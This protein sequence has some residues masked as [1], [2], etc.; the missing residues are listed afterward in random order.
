MTTANYVQKFD[1]VPQFWQFLKGLRTDDLLVELIQNDLDASAKHTMISFEPDRLVCQGDGDPVEAE[2]WERLSYVMGA[3]DQVQSKQF[4]IGVK[5]HGLK[6]CFN[7]GDD[8]T[9]RS[10]GL[11]TVQTLYMDGPDSHP[12]PGTLPCPEADYSAPAE[13]CSVEVPYRTKKLAVSKGEPFELEPTDENYTDRLFLEACSTLPA[14]LMGVVFPGVRDH[15][16]LSLNHHKLG[17]VEIRWK[18]KRPKRIA[19]KGRIRFT[20]FSRECEV[21]SDVSSVKSVT[22]YEQACAFRR[23]TPKGINPEV[24]EFFQPEKKSFRMETAWATDRHGRPA[25]TRGVRRYPIGY[26]G[27]ADSALSCLGAHFA[28]PYRSDGERH[29]ASSQDPLNAHID[30]ACREALVDIMACYLLPRHG[31]RVMAL[32]VAEPQPNDES[33]LDMLRRSIEKKAIPIEP[34]SS[35]SRRRQKPAV[36]NKRQGFRSRSCLGPRR[37]PSGGT[38]RILIPAFTWDEE[39]VAP[40]LSDLCPAGE[41]QIDK[42][43]PPSVFKHLAKYHFAGSIITFNET[44]VINRLQPQREDC[45]FP[46]QDASEWRSCISNAVTAGKYLDVAYLAVQNGELD[47]EEEVI[48][49]V[50]LPDLNSVLRPLCELHSGVTL[51]SGLQN[52]H[53]GPILHHSLKDHKLLRKQAWKPRPF[54]IDD[55]LDRVDLENATVDQRKL[56]WRWLRVNWRQLKPRTRRLLATLPIWPDASGCPRRL[57]ELCEPDN[58]RISSVMGNFLDRPSREIL[59]SRMVK[60][61]GRG[62]LALRRRPS[63]KEVEEFLLDGLEAFPLDRALYREER[64]EFRDFEA[65]LSVLANVPQ[66]KEAL[67]ELSEGYGVALNGDGFLKN[68]AGLV[69]CRKGTDVLHLLSRHVIDRSESVLD[70]VKGWSGRSEPSSSQIEEALR[71]DSDRNGAYVPRLQMYVKQS[72]N[73]GMSP[74]RISDLPCIPV[75]ESLYS[76]VQLALRGQRDYWGSWKTRI[77]VGGINPEVQQIY[78]EVGVVAGEPDPSS[79][80]QFFEWLNLQPAGIIAAHTDQILR[81]IQH[82]SGPCSWE[83]TYPKVPFIPVEGKDGQVR[84]ITK[85]QATKRGNRVVIPDFEPLQDGIRTSQGNRIAELAIAESRG[86]REPITSELLRLGLNSLKEIAREP[87][88]VTGEGNTEGSPLNLLRALKAL[89]SGAMGQQLPKRLD[90][91]GITKDQNKLRS[92]MRERLSRVK[93]VKVA[94]TVTAKY[95]LARKELSV[96]TPGRLDRQS[97]S[98]WLRS[99]PDIEESFFDVIADLVFEQPQQYLGSVLQRACKMELRERNPR[100]M[101]DDDGIHDGPD[102]DEPDSPGELT[103]ITG[104][105]PLPTPDPSR[106]SPNPGPIPPSSGRSRHSGKSTRTNTN[107]PQ[108]A[109]ELAQIADLKENQYA[110][111][112]QACLSA[113][114]PMTLAPTSSYAFLHQNRRQIMEA[115]HCDQVAAGGARHAGNLLLLCNYHHLFFGDAVSRGELVHS[116]HSMV[117]HVVVFPSDDGRGQPVSGKLVKVHP[118]QREESISLFF[119]PWHLEYWKMKASEEGIN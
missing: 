11:R 109:D 97:E 40:L 61:T 112:C 77:P 117:D 100:L 65:A 29:G 25:S 34:T 68:P 33:T 110:W 90:R 93:S 85:L 6:A 70:R 92:N 43:V 73:E 2:G 64:K 108:P 96:Q 30:E 16:T 69:R 115:H 84:L 36:S 10:D 98:I 114:E 18:A 49:N 15:Y 101:L 62:A 45:V 8:I 76:P 86:V 103:S 23:S 21:S 12:S 48:Q 99:G 56:F 50:Y 67:E 28:G 41:D 102:I 17:R 3:G 81:H 63:M 104:S 75:G 71:E 83:S 1:S 54:T 27:T 91:L 87:V 51:P 58:K 88:S 82:R 78:K 66:L 9:V 106:N 5:N 94:E 111:H 22:L 116:F 119:T 13:G 107:R 80:R 118:P 7:L 95:Q 37:N 74:D 31:A 55:Y 32:Y 39:R 59:R 53:F 72:K 4:R 57:D 19:A 52:Q 44:D 42:S 89:Q 105:H 46:W 60:S 14:R 35:P 20:L 24:P 113:A 79:S 47:S 26:S 38:K